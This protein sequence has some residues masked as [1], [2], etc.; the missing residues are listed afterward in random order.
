MKSSEHQTPSS[1]EGPNIKFQ[2]RAAAPKTGVATKCALWM[3]GASLE[4]GD[5]NL[6]FKNGEI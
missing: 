5:W 6:E 1:R 2:N 4:L 3:L